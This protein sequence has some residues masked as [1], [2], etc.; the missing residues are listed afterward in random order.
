[1]ECT[2]A[3]GIPDVYYCLRGVSG[4]A[5]LKLF[6]RVGKAPPHLTREQVLWGEEEARLGGNWWLVG[7]AGPV[8]LAYDAAGARALFEGKE[9]ESCPKMQVTGRFPL[10]ELLD[11]LAPR[12]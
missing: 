4:W 9:E 5:E 2:T 6:P 11:L 8:W 1:M 12:P 7:R 3:L 10:R